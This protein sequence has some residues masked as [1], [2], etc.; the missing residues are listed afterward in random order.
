VTIWTDLSDLAFAVTFVDAGGLRTRA[1]QSGTGEDVVFLH[2]TSGHLEA[3]VRNIPAHAPHYRCHAIDMMGHGYT[4]APDRPYR[5]PGY[6]DHV[7]DYLDAVGI[8]RAHFVGESLGGWVA[9]R[10][11]VEHPDRVGKLTLVAPGGTVANPE[12]MARIKNSTR[13][14]VETDDVELTR[15]RLELLMYDAAKDVSDELVQV[16]HAIYHRP[17]FVAAI[18][19]LL[20]LQEM[21]NR[22]PDL[23]T[24]EQMG[25]ITAPT[26]IVWG[27]ENP[28]GEVPEAERMH[29]AI[30]GSHL[31]IFERCGHW[32]QHEH[33]QRF[34]DLHLRFLAGE[35]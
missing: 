3:F 16:R 25:A 1:L 9:A 2:G 34:N 29:K 22:K 32:P 27:A 8:E 5:I 12:V 14:A 23:L 17:T 11:A 7:V 21:E 13:A 28:F 15:R 4:D 33:A 35:L 6:V 18:D 10:L 26:L 19:R 30:P 31:E 20:A 24:E